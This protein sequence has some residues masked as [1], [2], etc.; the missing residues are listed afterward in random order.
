MKQVKFGGKMLRKFV[1]VVSAVMLVI[2]IACKGQGGEDKSAGEEGKAKTEQ[3][4]GGE[5]KCQ[6]G[7]CGE[8]KCGGGK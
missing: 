2:G 6:P 3:T 7:K 1:L 8:G 4:A 5:M